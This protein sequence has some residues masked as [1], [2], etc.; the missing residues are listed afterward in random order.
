MTNCSGCKVE[1]SV[2]VPKGT[3]IYCKRCA[4]RVKAPDKPYDTLIT[5]TLEDL[6]QEYQEQLDFDLERFHKEKICRILLKKIMFLL[7]YRAVS[8]DAETFFMF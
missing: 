8:I 1:L 6:I 7:G 3:E 2:L 5:L 4:S